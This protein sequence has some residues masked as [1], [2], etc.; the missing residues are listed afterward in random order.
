MKKAQETCRSCP[1]LR[2]CPRTS[3]YEH[4]AART[5]NAPWRPRP[6]RL[7]K[8][9]HRHD[10]GEGRVRIRS[11]NGWAGGRT[12]LGGLR[13]ARVRRLGMLCAAGCARRVRLVDDDYRIDGAE[14]V[15]LIA[16]SLWSFS[17]RW[18]SS[19]YR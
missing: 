15:R 1:G 4:A 6:S 10:G 14:R 18:P 13:P 7:M 12:H 9:R 3:E 2:R 16:V 8:L 5:L 19:R 17:Q 11:A